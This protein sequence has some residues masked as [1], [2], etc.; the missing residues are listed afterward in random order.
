MSL[1]FNSEKSIIMHFLQ[2]FFCSILLN[3]LLLLLIAKIE[4]VIPPLSALLNHYL[5]LHGC[6]P[7][8]KG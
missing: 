8:I 2:H 1:W 5:M 7:Y 3:N 4:T 6:P